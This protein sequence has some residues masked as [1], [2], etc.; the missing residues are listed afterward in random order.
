[1]SPARLRGRAVLEAQ[2]AALRRHGAGDDVEFHRGAADAL[3]WLIENT[4]SPLTGQ[5]GIPPVSAQAIVR[6]LACAEEIIYGGSPRHRD[7]CR[8]VEHALMWAQ[9]ATAAP[10]L[11]STRQRG[12][13]EG[14][15]LDKRPSGVHHGDAGPASGP[16]EAGQQEQ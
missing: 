2:L 3:R 13:G 12:P 5:L 4:A 8:G 16:G 7:Y 14:C 15:R 1:V 10:P 11:P 6:E 9:F